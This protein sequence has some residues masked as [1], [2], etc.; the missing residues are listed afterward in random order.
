MKC[1]ECG[2]TD[3]RLSRHEIALDMV[4]RLEIHIHHCPMC[5]WVTLPDWVW[6][7]RDEQER[8]P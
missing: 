4:W 2:Y 8:T 6:V 7:G 3:T 1:P 5:G